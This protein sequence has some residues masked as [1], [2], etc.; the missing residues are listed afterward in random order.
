MTVAKRVIVETDSLRQ[1]VGEFKI[2]V[3]K[4]SVM[5]ELF[6]KASLEEFKQYIKD[7]EEVIY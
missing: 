7:W 6:P 4:L 1:L 5:H 3:D 2:L